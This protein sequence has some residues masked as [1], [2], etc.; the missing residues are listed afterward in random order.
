MNNY[1]YFCFD[2]GAE[3]PARE[4]ESAFHYLCPKCGQAEANQPL[5]GVLWIRYDY[6]RLKQELNKPE[7]INLPAGKFWLWPQLWPLS[8]RSF[9]RKIFFDKID[10]GQLEKLFLSSNPLLHEEAEGREILIWDETRN[11]TLSFKD[12]ATSLVILK[13]MQLGVREIAAASTGNAG[14]SLAG[15]CVRAGLTAHI[16][17]P[18]SIPAAKRIQIQAYGAELILVDGSYDEAFDLCL[19]VAQSKHWYNRNTAYNPLTIEGKKS[20]AYDIFILTKGELP[21][22][23]FVPV[24]DG[25]IISGLFKGF[26]ELQQL[27]WIHKLPRLIAVQAEGSN[28]LVRFLQTGHFEFKKGSTSADSI[29]ADAPRNLFMA[30][31]AVKESNG[32][33][34]AVSNEEMLQ[35]QKFIAQKMGILVELSAAASLAGYLRLQAQQKISSHEKILLLFTGNG[36]KDLSALETWNPVTNIETVSDWKKKLL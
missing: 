30:A 6:E 1:L 34:V 16:F 25:V 32:A 29:H 3:F 15:L 11:P 33:A 36:L 27:G 26:W 5:Q 13:A 17:A 10:D 35:A 31:H 24:G 23:I 28:A 9:S 22:I 8:Y 21:D 2:C 20:A 4:I 18:K 14:S 7:F 19:E 12:R